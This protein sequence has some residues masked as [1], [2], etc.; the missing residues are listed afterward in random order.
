MA[1]A[2]FNF[3]CRDLVAWEAI[4]AGLSAVGGAPASPLAVEA[5][6]Q[7]GLD[8]S[9]HLSQPLIK[10]LVDTVTMAVA[11]T[12]SHLD[13]ALARFPQLEGRL[14]LLGDFDAQAALGASVPDP[15]GG[16]LAD[17]LECRETIRRGVEGLARTLRQRRNT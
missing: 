7:L 11:M 17:Y 2:F 6:A 10:R 4:S 13:G 5:M 16:T 9:R 15:F 3:G 12:T 1:E 8:L 14:W